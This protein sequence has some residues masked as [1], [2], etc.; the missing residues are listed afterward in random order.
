VVVAWAE[1]G[2]QRAKVV[3]LQLLIQV[4]VVVVVEMERLPAVMAVLV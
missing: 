1:T 2:G 3:V 4:V